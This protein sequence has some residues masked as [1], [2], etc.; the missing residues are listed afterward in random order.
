MF[1]LIRLYRGM[2]GSVCWP[3]GLSTG[4][5]VDTKVVQAFL[6]TSQQ[7]LLQSLLLQ[8]HKICSKFYTALLRVASIH[9][10][11]CHVL[12]ACCHYLQKPTLVR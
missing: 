1:L 9:V 2:L 8:R 6:S 5:H 4:S 10:S 7:L 12:L 11:L 3:P